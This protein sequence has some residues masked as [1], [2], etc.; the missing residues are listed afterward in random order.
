[1]PSKEGTGSHNM[2]D[3]PISVLFI[4]D[5]TE[6]ADLVHAWLGEYGASAFDISWT[7]SLNAGLNRLK[8][9][10]IDLILLDLGL[11]DSHGY[12][13]FAR[14]QS[15]A[16]GLP[17]VLLTGEDNTSLALQLMQAGAQ[18]Y[19]L[20][21]T[22]T[23]EILSRTIRFAYIRQLTSGPS[24]DSKTR[25]S[26]VIGVMGAKG[27][28]GTT[29]IA[30]TLAMEISQ[31]TSEP[32]V[33]LDLDLDS[34]FVGLTLNLESTYS[35]LDLV[36]N[37]HRLDTQ[38]LSSLVVKYS[39]DLSVSLSPATATEIDPE[40]LR[41][42]LH[43][44]QADYRWIVLDMG[45]LNKVSLNLLDKTDEIFLITLTTVPALFEVKR[46]LARLAVAGCNLE[47]LKLIVNHTE[48]GDR[49]PLPQL[50]KLFGVKTCAEVPYAREDFSELFGSARMLPASGHF[51]TA[52]APVAA[53]LA[54]LQSSSTPGFAHQLA[55]FARKLRGA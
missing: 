5:N 39:D 27:G 21:S 13:S 37:L 50:A 33:L 14:I 30:C 11:P 38:L 18:D 55:S 32:T 23:G 20:K 42:L 34:G 35:V 31:L 46:M 49:I 26:R 22:C 43:F 19:L 51:R 25:A 54:G 3:R 8:Q 9:G 6:F 15:A 47:R 40:K 29:S 7:D 36:A 28:V 2:S 1:M 41:V 48:T 12:E 53:S 16:S 24:T 52:V 4:D 17:I 10:G 45:R 44:L